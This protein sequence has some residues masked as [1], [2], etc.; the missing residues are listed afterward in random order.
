MLPLAGWEIMT[1]SNVKITTSDIRYVSLLFNKIFVLL[2][3]VYTYS[4][5]GAGRSQ[6]EGTSYSWL[7][8]LGIRQDREY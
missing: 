4:A 5:S 7:R 1:E 8:T 2:G 3:A 6:G